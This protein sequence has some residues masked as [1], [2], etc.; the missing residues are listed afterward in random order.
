MYVSQEK[1]HSD[2]PKAA[3]PGS[4]GIHPGKQICRLGGSSSVFQYINKYD[5]KSHYILSDAMII[6]EEESSDIR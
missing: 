3:P 6:S 4:A 5:K 2:V 1:N